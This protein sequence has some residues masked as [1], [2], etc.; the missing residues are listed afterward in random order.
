LAPRQ[1]NGMPSPHCGQSRAAVKET[2]RPPPRRWVGSWRP[3][4]DRGNPR[5]PASAEYA[6]VQISICRSRPRRRPASGCGAA[7]VR[8]RWGAAPPG[9]GASWG[10]ARAGVRRRRGAARAGCG[11]AGVRR[12]VEALRGPGAGRA[13]MRGAIRQGGRTCAARA[14]AH[15]QRG[16][17]LSRAPP[18][19]H[20]TPGYQA[21]TF[22]LPDR[23]TNPDRLPI[24]GQAHHLVLPISARLPRLVARGYPG[25]V[26]GPP[27]PVTPFYDE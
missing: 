19:Q 20:V 23:L 25:A 10:A 16:G 17:A 11:A 3:R 5:A 24:S 18:R 15:M 26:P 6:V 1:P 8:R 12:E 2:M 27:W 9:C 14:G 22:I 4:R 13:G 21:C 7:G